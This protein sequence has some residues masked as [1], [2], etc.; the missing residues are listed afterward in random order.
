VLELIPILF[1]IE[2]LGFDEDSKGANGTW[3]RRK[4]EKQAVT[5]SMRFTALRSDLS[6]LI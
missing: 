4:T 1:S 6:R 5:R 3:G 2:V